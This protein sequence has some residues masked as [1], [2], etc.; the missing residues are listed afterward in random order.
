MAV[1]ALRLRRESADSYLSVL[2]IRD[3]VTLCKAKCH[4]MWLF[5][6]YTKCSFVSYVNTISRL[7]ASDKVVKNCLLQYVW[8]M[9]VAF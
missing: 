4:E 7:N 6:N 8:D 2:L 3:I 5:V 9:T 1:E